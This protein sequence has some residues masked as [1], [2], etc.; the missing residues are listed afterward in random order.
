MGQKQ[1]KH[2][3]AQLYE[4]DVANKDNGIS[5]YLTMLNI[6]PKQILLYAT[7]EN[8]ILT[9]WPLGSVV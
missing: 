1:Q 5:H 4:F 6:C 9:H 2:H 3:W 8:L 7:V